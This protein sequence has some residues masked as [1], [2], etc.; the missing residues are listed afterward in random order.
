MMNKKSFIW[1]NFSLLEGGIYN[2]WL[3][4]KIMSVIL[5]LIAG[6]VYTG[7]RATCLSGVARV[8]RK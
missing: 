4:V 5:D 2:K 7:K 1:K 6:S 8:H 3:R